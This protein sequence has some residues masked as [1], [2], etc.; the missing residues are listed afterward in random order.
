ML[1]RI[2]KAGRSCNQLGC[3]DRV[4]SKKRKRSVDPGGARRFLCLQMNAIGDAVMAQPAWSAIGKAFPGATIDLACSPHIAPLFENDPALHRIHRLRKSRYR[5]WLFEDGSSVRETLRGARYDVI[6]DFSALPLTAN[7]CAQEE[8]PFSVGFQRRMEGWRGGLDLGRAYDGTTPYSEE[9]HCRALMLHLAN[10]ICNLDD[11]EPAPKIYTDDASLRKAS[12][13]LESLGLREGSF[14]TIHPGA[15]WSPKIWPAGHWQ[16]LIRKLRDDMDASLFLLGGIQDRKIMDEILH[17]GSMAG[18]P[19]HV[20][21]DIM[22]SAALIR[23]SA[24]CL[25]HDSAPM[26]MAAALGVKSV[27][28]FGPVLPSRSAPP[29]SEGCRALHREM[30]CSPCTLYYAGERCRRGMNFCMHALGPDE[31]FRAVGDALAFP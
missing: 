16:T 29:Q 9:V 30:F 20:S 31:V 17:E 5:P 10:V 14:I 28:L 12:A 4:L 13:V 11:P 25:C 2:I 23:L 18:V 24:L 3:M 8:M 6:V 27:A 21:D 22:L 26:H 19:R 15:K 1:R 7:L